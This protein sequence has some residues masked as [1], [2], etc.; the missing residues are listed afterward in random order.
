ML[1]AYDHFSHIPTKHH[2]PLNDPVIQNLATKTEICSK[3]TCVTDSAVVITEVSFGIIR[4]S[5]VNT[6]IC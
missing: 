4:L 3:S 5:E 6:L 2:Q 1:I